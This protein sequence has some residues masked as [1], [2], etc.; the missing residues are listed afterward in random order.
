MEEPEDTEEIAKHAR[1]FLTN[2]CL[3]VLGG[4]FVVWVS[5]VKGDSYSVYV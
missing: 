1:S 2:L 4:V 5:W 3:L